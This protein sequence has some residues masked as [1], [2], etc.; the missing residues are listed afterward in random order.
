MKAADT[1]KRSESTEEDDGET[2]KEVA[3]CITLKIHATNT[4]NML[5]DNSSRHVLFTGLTAVA[6]DQR[7]FANLF[8]HWKPL[9]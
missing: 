1:K 3:R 5:F 8:D 9:F 2:N 6:A 4:G 7:I